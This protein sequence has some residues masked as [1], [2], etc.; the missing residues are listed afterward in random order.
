[1]RIVVFYGLFFILSILLIVL[2]LINYMQYTTLPR[3]KKEI[4]VQKSTKKYLKKRDKFVPIRTLEMAQKEVDILL[5]KTPSLFYDRAMELEQNS[6]NVVV[7]NP[8]KK[9]LFNL[10]RVF[11]HLDEDAI[12]I[13]NIYSNSKGSQ[14]YNLELSQK[15]ADYLKKYF[16][17][18]TS[19][20]LIVAIGYGTTIPLK[21]VEM[22][23]KRIK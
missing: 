22:N 23:L 9:R 17:E 12:L 15:Y 21:K 14:Q 3:E 8:I 2:T 18:R 19:L 7:V 6:S 11:N 4:R 13:I 5:E 16:M 10:V 20:P 1:M